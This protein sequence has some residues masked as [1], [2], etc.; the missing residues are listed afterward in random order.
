LRWISIRNGG[1]NLASDNEIN[2]LTMGG[3]G[4]GT[5]IE[6]IEVFANLDD[7][8]EWFGGTVNTS[9]LVSAFNDDDTFDMD[10]GFRGLHQFWFSIIG[11]GNSNGEHGGEHDGGTDPQDGEPFTNPTIANVTYIGA[12]AEGGGQDDSGGFQLRD[13]YSGTYINSIFT[14]FVDDAIEI[15]SDGDT[16]ARLQ[17]GSIVFDNNIWWN[18][19][20]NEGTGEYDNT[21]A[22]FSSDAG[23]DVSGF[24][25]GTQAFPGENFDNEIADPALIGISRQPDGG[26]DP[27]PAMSSPAVSGAGTVPDNGFHEQTTFRGAFGADNWAKGWTVLDRLGYFPASDES[28][29]ED[30]ELSGISTRGLVGAGEFEN[31]LNSSVI[32]LGTDPMDVVFRARSTSINLEGVDLLPDPIIDV[33]RVGEGVIAT[34]DSFAEADNL[35]LLTGTQF[36]PETVGMNPEEALLILLDLEPGAYSVRVRSAVEGETGLA[37]AEAFAVR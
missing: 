11:A 26:L 3:V 16:P 10:E 15:E 30:N 32:I 25:D 5:T 31:V 37:I 19:S 9:N 8:F 17:E 4:R 13:N 33:V 23:E 35:D 12:G 2:G 6:Y 34:N 14:E 1:S 18:F 20:L 21:P 29:A 7:G 28:T 27:R 24:W 22:G 36:D